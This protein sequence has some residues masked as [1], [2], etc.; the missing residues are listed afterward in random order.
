MTLLLDCCL[1]NI[2]FSEN[3]QRCSVNI[4]VETPVPI[5]NTEVKHCEAEGS[6]SKNR[7]M[8]L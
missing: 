6:E 3:Y 1:Y 2:Q 8:L 7:K 5:P 4:A